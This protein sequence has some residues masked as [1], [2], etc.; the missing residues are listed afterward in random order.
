MAYP[1]Q[2]TGQPADQWQP[3][4]D[5]QPYQWDDAPDSDPEDDPNS[6]APQAAIPTSV[7]NTPGYQPVQGYEN[8]GFGEG[9]AVPPPPLAVP[10]ETEKPKEEY[11]SASNISEDDARAAMIQFVSEHCCYGSKPAKEMN[12][13]SII[14]SSA[15]HYQL[16]TFSESR[17]T[18]RDFLPYMGYELIDGP[19]NGMAPPVWNI[20]CTPTNLFQDEIKELEVPHTAFVAYGLL[21]ISILESMNQILIPKLRDIVNHLS[22]YILEKSDMP[23]E[24][25][26]GVSGTTIFEQTLPFVWPISAYPVPEISA[27]S[28]RLVAEH[29]TFNMERQ[30]QQRQRLRAVPVSEV[31]YTWK[32]TNTR[33]WVYGNEHKVHAP[34]YPQQCCCGCSIL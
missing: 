16:E 24:L 7:E 3:G 20:M 32:D 5:G 9:S 2:P 8:V 31:A 34:D 23:D 30:L 26:R 14:P 18:S 28:Q 13:G 6:V 12:I 33:F 29:Q 4:Q 15:L 21:I 11:S 1:G 17:A 25:I 19:M 22:D 27:N 10:A